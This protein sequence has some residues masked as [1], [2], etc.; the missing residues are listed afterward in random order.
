MLP[1]AIEAALS[2]AHLMLREYNPNHDDKG[3]FGSGA[4]ARAD[5]AAGDVLQHRAD[6]AAAMRAGDHQAAAKAQQKEQHA[7]RSF[8]KAKAIQAQAHAEQIK[9]FAKFQVTKTTTSGKIV[10][11]PLSGGRYFVAHTDHKGQ[12]MTSGRIYD[13]SGKQIATGNAE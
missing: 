7:M 1:L 10:S 12:P 3:R 6:A 4:G 2:V 9:R 11:K 13:K 8:L 5:S